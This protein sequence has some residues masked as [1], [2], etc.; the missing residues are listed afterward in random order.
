M[1]AAQSGETVVPSGP[2]LGGSVGMTGFGGGANGEISSGIGW[3]AH[4]SYV[5]NSGLYASGGV[6]LSKHDLANDVAP[7]QSVSFFVE[8]RWIALRLS[9][10]FAPFV[11]ARAARVSEKVPGRSYELKASGTLFG[12]GGGVLLR[13]APQIALE[14]G[15]LF[16]SSRFDAYTFV[17]EFAWK[18]C[19][20][21]LDAGTPLPRSVSECSGSRSVGGV[22]NLCYPPYFPERTSTCSP[23]EIPYEDTG[24]SGTWTRTWIGVSLAL[25]GGN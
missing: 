21:A 11:A 16:G 20:D 25:S 13:L 19:L 6:V 23:P 10:S 14:A 4:L 3:E 2:G 12:A 18:T 15:F 22:L 24:R 8:P 17:G 5:L 1:V 9:P 7:W